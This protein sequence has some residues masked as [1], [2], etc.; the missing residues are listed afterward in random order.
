MERW[1]T[2]NMKH[3][4]YSITSI[5]LLLAISCSTSAFALSA[6]DFSDYNSK[7][8]YS[9]AIQYVVDNGI[10]YG[11]DN[12]KLE[13]DRYI[14]RAEFVSMVDRLFGTYNKADI[15]KYKDMKPSDWYYNNI[16]MGVK[17]G[18]IFGDTA[19]TI[20]PNGYITREQA[21]V[22]LSRTLGLSDG[23]YRD[24][25]KFVDNKDVS[26]W[27]INSVG[28]MVKDGRVAGFEDGTLKPKNNITRAETAQLLYK[29]FPELVEDTL[30][31]EYDT[32]VILSS[33]HGA[34]VKDTRVGD[35]L[36]LATGLADNRVDI[37]NSNINRLLCWGSKDVYIY[38][39]CSFE[40]IVISRTDG[41]CIIH[42]M[43]DTSK[44]LP[45][46]E[47]K[48]SSDPGCK[49]VDKNG[50]QIYPKINNNGGNNIEDDKEKHYPTV[51][52][53]SQNGSSLVKQRIDDTGHVQPITDPV[54]TG[55]VFGGWYTD[56]ECDWRFSFTQQATD[57]MTLYAR[58]YTPEEH[59][60]V[61]IMNNTVQKSSTGIYAETD[62]MAIIGETSIPCNISSHVSNVNNIKIELV[63]S[64]TNTVIA[65]IDS[66]APGATVTTMNLVSD[67]PD[68]GE[69]ATKLL[70]TPENSTNCIEIE[71][72]L[73]VGYMWNRG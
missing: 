65:R 21:I 58:W 32:N 71:S 62:L 44:G 50:K 40:K 15:T 10:M 8:W 41:P 6:S 42:W 39:G 29:C 49:V 23:D 28:A 35:T 67:M 27:A 3:K 53:D 55:Y 47:I 1:E 61:Q 2:N 56:R 14:T 37:R 73:Y 20:N 68:Y 4:L 33:E 66:L 18:T 30:N 60:Q 46:F 38:E 59:A 12:S 63:M 64:G 31:G 19:N 70:V 9:N 43:G 45:E 17:M 5:A 22:I 11:T 24:I 57:G 34:S 26:N 51:Y 16:A 48:N 7:A 54:K 52:F 69:Y 72:V 36:I 13:P 25:S